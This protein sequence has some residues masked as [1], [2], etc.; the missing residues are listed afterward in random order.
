MPLGTR[1]HP[2]DFPGGAPVPVIPYKLHERVAG[3]VLEVTAAPGTRVSA[4]LE[5]QT[6][7]GRRFRFH[8]ARR[9][10]SEGAARLRVPYDTEGKG[11]TRALGP[12]RVEAGRQR[13]DISVSDTAVRSGASIR[14]DMTAVAADASFGAAEE[15]RPLP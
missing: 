15:R 3:A 1:P 10:D 8:A 4:E 7:T 12:Y 5:L 13:S 14:L 11:P 9:S 6:N 2:S